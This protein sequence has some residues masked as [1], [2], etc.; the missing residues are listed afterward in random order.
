MRRIV[1][2]CNQMRHFR[3]HK[4]TTLYLHEQR[5]FS[6]LAYLCADAFTNAL[7]RLL[8]TSAKILTREQKK[9]KLYTNHNGDGRT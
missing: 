7:Y 5:T 2:R 9:N 6:K 1:L 3:L 8:L 4:P